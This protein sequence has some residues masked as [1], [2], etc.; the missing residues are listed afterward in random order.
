MCAIRRC[1]V[2]TTTLLSTVIFKYVSGGLLFVCLIL[3][4]ALKVED[5]A[6]RAQY[7]ALLRLLQQVEE[8]PDPLPP[9][10]QEFARTRVRNTRGEVVGEVH[11]QNA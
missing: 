6:A 7:P 4:I 2:G 3:G 1:A 5:G 11:V 8:L 10:L 9:R